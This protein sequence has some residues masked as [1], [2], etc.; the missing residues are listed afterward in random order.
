MLYALCFISDRYNMKMNKPMTITE[1]ILAVHADKK[2]VS[3]GDLLDARIDLALGNDITAPLAIQR[4]SF[5]P[6]NVK[7]SE[8]LQR[9]IAS[10]IILR[11][12]KQGSSMPFSLKRGW[13]CQAMW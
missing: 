1:K 6:N 9:P 12:E 8:I 2:Q 5:L 3:P 4:T 10:P 7:S 13:S 11:S